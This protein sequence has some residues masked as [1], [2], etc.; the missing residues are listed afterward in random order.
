[1]LSTL[2]DIRLAAIAHFGSVWIYCR[3]M[4]FQ[5]ILGILCV[6]ICESKGEP[7]SSDRVCDEDECTQLVKQIEAQRGSSGPCVNFHDY[8]CGKWN[9]SQEIPKPLKDKAVKDLADLLD[10]CS[11]LTESP[12]ATAKLM[13]AYMSCTQKA[14]KASV[15]N[16]LKGYNV[17]Q[18]PLPS[19]AREKPR[20]T[21]QEILGKVGPLP[22]F[23]YFISE[24]KSARIIR[25]TMPTDFYVSGVDYDY[26]YDPDFAQSV[27]DSEEAY[28]E[29]ITETIVILSD[30]AT[31]KEA[32]KVADEIIYFEK[33]ISKIA[34][35]VKP[36]PKIM[37]LSSLNE[38]LTIQENKFHMDEILQRDFQFV[39]VFITEENQVEV[40]YLQYYKDVAKYLKHNSTAVQLANYILWTKIRNMA[41]AVQTPLYDLY[42][43]Y[44]NETSIT[45]KGNITRSNNTK[46]TC[47]RQLLESEIMYTAGASYYSSVKFGNDSRNQVMKMLPFINST[48][49]Y[50]IKKNTWMSPEY[51]NETIKRINN[52]TYLIGYPDWILNST[53]VNSLYQ[54]V[55][56]ISANASFV[57]HFHWL[58]ENERFQ[59]L[60]KIKSEYFD[61][62]NEEV[63]LRS[64]AFYNEKSNIL[65]YP[66]AALVTH[67]RSPPI[68]RAM[69]FGTIG[70]IVA[71]AL[72]NAIDRF[73]G[74]I[75]EVN[76][77][78]NETAINFCEKSMCLNNTKECINISVCNN[79]SYQKLEDYFGV[80]VSHMAMRRSKKNYSDP[81][82][83]PASGLKTEDK[84]F[85]TGFGSLY[86]PFSV[87]EEK[88]AE[89]KEVQD[90]PLVKSLKEV[91]SIYRNFST[92]FNCSSNYTDTCNLMPVVTAPTGC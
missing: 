80:R 16:I 28:K 78:D 61:K 5:I 26:D 68:P 54:Y 19:D 92:A 52:V 48:L 1:M 84:I 34:S 7:R 76:K 31:K 53:T 18:W 21:Y 65:G 85:F 9:G 79:S 74:T 46:L 87:N 6:T 63:A 38:I 77:W 42:L 86:C 57:E 70:T 15:R 11:T 44:E 72:I 69:N 8:I 56:N 40:K 32:A 90:D 27:K 41:K 17:S 73:D 20:R 75:T 62:T 2:H 4:I 37:N 81:F 60:R 22:L 25:M 14:L 45:D 51:K 36:E 13:N 33:N 3:T 55:P 10:E 50:V 30:N 66:A 88:V 29:F 35:K 49:R 58:Q 67:Y 12:N 71:Q 43:R 64:H 91:V 82:L 83:L 89:K 59:N 39:N 23:P 24:K 47:M